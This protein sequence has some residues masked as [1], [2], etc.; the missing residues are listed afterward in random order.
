[1]LVGAAAA[2]LAGKD[3]WRRSEDGQ[4]KGRLVLAPGDYTIKLR[5]HLKTV[6]ENFAFKRVSVTSGSTTRVRFEIAGS[7]AIRIA[8]AS[9][10]A[11]ALSA[12]LF[13]PLPVTLM[14]FRRARQGAEAISWRP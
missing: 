1:M 4:W 11:R 2:R 14:C 10:E 9:H 5:Y 3:G 13:S 7:A 6:S 12:F 8:V